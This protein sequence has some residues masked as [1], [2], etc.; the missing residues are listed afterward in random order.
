MQRPRGFRPW[1]SLEIVYGGWK[2]RKGKEKEG[3]CPEQARSSA[4]QGLLLSHE[5]LGAGAGKMVLGVKVI[6]AKPDDLS[7]IPRTYTW[8]KKKK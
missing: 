6:A 8:W 2:A 7:S 1:G 3:A 4:V 5:A